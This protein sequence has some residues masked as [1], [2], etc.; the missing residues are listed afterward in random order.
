[1]LNI[2][3]TDPARRKIVELMQQ[4]EQPV[5]GLRIVANA[6]S[7]LN[8]EYSLAFVYEDEIFPD[9]TVVDIGDFEVYVDAESVPYMDGVILDFLDN[10]MGGNFRIDAPP[11]PAPKLEGPLAERLQKLIQE[12]IN[13]ALASHGGF[14]HLVDVKDNVAYI[15]MGGGCQGCGL[16]NVTLKRGIEMMIKR[17]IPEIKE[18]LDVTD[19]A[20]GTNPYYKRT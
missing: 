4:M 10:P 2:K 13:P 19:H 17:N 16:A 12:Q 3:I 14:V 6:R 18:V 9:D 20:R 11:P 8:V 5:K 1:M 7:P 15:E